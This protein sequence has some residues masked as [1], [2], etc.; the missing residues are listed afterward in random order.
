MS[1][2]RFDAFSKPCKREEFLNKEKKL[3]FISYAVQYWGD[4]VRDAGPQSLDVVDAAVGY[5]QNSSRI[6]AYIQAAWMVDKQAGD[7]WDVRRNVHPLRRFLF[8]LVFSAAFAM[9]RSKLIKISLF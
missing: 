5:L 9:L 1:F 3:P 7:K 6:E 8:S 2:L 4:H